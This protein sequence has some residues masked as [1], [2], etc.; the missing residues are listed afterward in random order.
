[1]E[2]LERISRRMLYVLMMAAVMFTAA[3]IAGSSDAYAA[4]SGAGTESDPY[5]IETDA[6]WEDF[7]GQVRAGESKDKYYKLDE[8]IQIS[9]PVGTKTNPFE[10]HIFGNGEWMIKATISDTNDGTAVFRYIK[11][12]SLEKLNVNGT[13]R[14]GKHAAAVV[15]FSEGTNTLSKVHVIESA[16]VIGGDYVGGI[17]G[18][19]LDSDLTLEDCWFDGTVKGSQYIGGLLGWS[20]GQKLTIRNCLFSGTRDCLDPVFHP[21]ALKNKNSS[22]TLDIKGAYYGSRSLPAVDNEYKGHIVTD[23]TKVYARADADASTG[24]FNKAVVIGQNTGYFYPLETFNVQLEKSFFQHTDTAINYTVT[25]DEETLN[26]YT[27]FTA[28]ISYAD[29]PNSKKYNDADI[30]KDANTYNLIING[31]GK[32]LGRLATQFVVTDLTGSG[33]ESDPYMIKSTGDWLQFTDILTKGKGETFEGKYV[34]LGADITM[35]T[36]AGTQEHPFCGTFDGGSHILTSN[37]ST[38]EQ[39]AAP[40]HCIKGAAIE[41]LTVTGTVQGDL[42]SSGLVGFA[43]GDRSVTNKINHVEVKAGITASDYGT[44]FVGHGKSSTIVITDSIFSGKVSCNMY[45]RR[46]SGAGFLA[47]NDGCKLIMT[48]CIDK[49]S[50]GSKFYWWNPIACTG[51]DSFHTDLKSTYYLENVAKGDDEYSAAWDVGAKLA[52]TKAI[53]GKVSTKVKAVDNNSYYIDEGIRLTGIK[54]VYKHTGNIILIPFD[55]KTSDG[56]LIN[57]DNYTERYNKEV[58]DKGAYTL[59]VTFTGDYTGTLSAS[60]KVADQLSGSGT[61][62]DPYLI[63]SAAD[64]N[65]FREALSSG[66]NYKNEYVKLTDDIA[67]GGNMAGTEANPF[68]GTFNGDGHKLTV[69]IETS[70][71]GAAPFA[72]VGASKITDLT[73]SG[74]VKGGNHASGLIGKVKDGPV[75]IT[76][77]TVLTMVSSGQYLGGFV[78]H[79]YDKGPINIIDCTFAGTLNCSGSAGYGGGFAGWADYPNYVMTGD[80]FKGRVTGTFKFFHPAGIYHTRSAGYA[81]RKGGMIYYTSSGSVRGSADGQTSPLEDWNVALTRAY[82]PNEA[83]EETLYKPLLINGKETDCFQKTSSSSITTDKSIYVTTEI[84]RDEYKPVTPAPVIECEG[85]TGIDL[86]YFTIRY[87]LNDE[88]SDDRTLVDEDNIGK[89]GT[90]TVE[91]TGDNEHYC[92][93]ISTSFRVVAFVGEGTEENPYGIYDTNDWGNFAAA[94]SAG[95]SFKNQFVTLYNDVDCLAAA[96]DGDHPFKGSFTG[97]RKSDGTYPVLTVDLDD[98]QSQG[99]APFRCAS[100]GAV[101][102]DLNVTGAIRGGRHAA[103]LVGFANSGKVEIDNVHV[104]AT[105]SVGDYVGGIVGHGKKSDLT[106]KDASFTGQITGGSSFAGGILG[107]SDGQ[108]LTIEKVVFSGQFFGSGSFH[109]IAVRNGGVSMNTT[110]RNVYYVSTQAPA[111][112]SDHAAAKGVPVYT[113]ATYPEDRLV[114]LVTAADGKDYY[115]ET[116]I[117]KLESSYEITRAGITPVPSV[118]DVT[119]KQLARANDYVAL[120]YNTDDPQVS[121]AKITEPGDYKLVLEGNRNRT[122]GRQEVGTFKVETNHVTGVSLNITEATLNFDEGSRTLQLE[123]TVVP[124]TASNR[125]VNWTSSDEAVATVDDTGFV[126]A[127]AEGSAVI[128]AVSKDQPEIK[129][130]CSIT[131]EKAK[132]AITAYP[133]PIALTYTGEQQQLLSAGASSGGKIV[134]KAPGQ[135]GFSED[136]PVGKNA[137]EYAIEYKVL[138]DQYHADSDV[139]TVAASIAKAPNGAVITKRAS[140]TTGGSLDLRTLVS[141]D[142][143]TG[144]TFTIAGDDTGSRIV[145]GTFTAGSPGNCAVTATLEGRANYLDQQEDILITIEEKEVK[146]D[147]NVVMEDLTFGDEGNDPSYSLPAGYDPE[148]VE[149]LYTGIE[150]GGQAYPQSDK[151]IGTRP[152]QAGSYSV[153]VFYEDEECIY[154][155][156]ANFMILPKDIEGAEVTL[157]E[158]LTYTGEEQ[159]QSVAKVMLGEAD[160]TDVCEVSADHAI[161]AG[162]YKMVI[163]AKEDSNYTGSIDQTFTVAKADPAFTPPTA[164]EL[165]YDGSIQVL[166]EPGTAEGGVMKYNNN[167]QGSFPDP[168][169]DG[170]EKLPVGQDAGTYLVNYVVKGDANHN[171]TPTQHLEVR[172]AEAKCTVSTAPEGISDLTYTGEEQALVTEGASSDGDMM[173][174]LEEDG[175]FSAAVPAA[176]D[177][178][179]YKVYYKAAA[180]DDN[181]ADSEV[182]GPVT[183]TIG[184]MASEI[185]EAPEAVTDLTYDGQEHALVTEGQAIG[186][187]MVYSLKEDGDFTAEIPAASDAGEYKVYYKVEGDDNITGTEV[188]G[189][190]EVTVGQ[191][192]FPGQ[193]LRG[194]VRAGYGEE[195]DLSQC[196]SSDLEL[197]YEIDPQASDAPG[198]QLDGSLLTTGSD[199]GKCYVEVKVKDKADNYESTGIFVVVSDIEWI[200]IRVGQKDIVYGEE[201]TPPA[202]EEYGSEDQVTSLTFIY[203]G[204]LTNGD[205]YGD[206]EDEVMTAPTEAGSYT[207]EVFYMIGKNAYS[208]SADFDILPA[209]INDAVVT[210]GKDLKYNGEFQTQEVEKVEINGK[211]ITDLCEISDNTALE[212]GNYQLTVSAKEGTYNCFGTTTVDF[213]VYPD[214]VTLAAAKY[215]ALEELDKTYDLSQYDEKTKAAVSEAIGAAKKAINDAKTLEEVEKAKKDAAQTISVYKMANTLTVKAKKVKVKASKLKKKTMTIKAAKANTVKEAQGTV[216]YKRGTI[217]AKKALLKQAKKKIKVAKNGKITLKKGLK[218][219]TYKVKI[220][221]SAAGNQYYKAGTKTVTVKIVV[222]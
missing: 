14:G 201:L 120:Y 39:G 79:S 20:D 148:K 188:M 87:Y 196:V 13:I 143:S 40:F 74:M 93:T 56:Q 82:S 219:G 222:K 161:N 37:V 2:Q 89:P 134:Y 49:G 202:Y 98:T 214:D 167:G 24:H 94:V 113:K 9:T 6:D 145:G 106:I 197:E 83:E 144:V 104:S 204:N 149:I 22:M 85:K 119:G 45:N 111:I 4:L 76:R 123:E 43:L 95:N 132:A 142:K 91:A 137:G 160:I 86:S 50:K 153:F 198:C 16:M 38:S 103:G 1:M 186:G 63:S 125:E 207:V 146:S 190:V 72:F 182:Q 159:Q 75:S 184:K 140:V 176:K 70:D 60:F 157:G 193:I 127:K 135:E 163:T 80:L 141:G 221:V 52:Y 174:S 136:I 65:T 34:K 150:R 187:K 88:D 108:K 5:L 138:G 209:D 194:A 100:D 162:E 147:L 205:V 29:N 158:A 3:A 105:V 78:G 164:K 97:N 112:D 183:V 195:V 55:V 118:A 23:G 12:A 178:G 71:Q 59:T 180:R 124:Q 73:V 8:N 107:W 15:G 211:D 215:L 90:Y 177:A 19:G 200:D 57:H 152:I 213:T 114:S 27:D 21:I 36:M 11:N 110:V 101:I 44:G 216:T 53:P 46:Y 189:P 54:P 128:T 116:V 166:I 35:R 84:E 212:M 62:E 170:N 109:P 191:A 203:Y 139:M 179:E 32:Y 99:T 185:I 26:K 51:S 58:K 10:G 47:M 218:K 129:A 126:T 220:K 151:D 155:D 217:K 172:I 171:N 173:Y 154:F 206:E 165:V 102:R 67:V 31:T 96:G 30:L 66:H 199:N 33:S 17:V 122:L 130:T 133:Q 48:N 181:H 117:G 131:V 69:N 61:A 18:H 210:L 169:Q 77:V 81:G 25:A 192:A 42:Y 41:N 168:D 208:G 121:L 7:A 68:S 28:E 175:E 92:G 156:G 64:W 115:A